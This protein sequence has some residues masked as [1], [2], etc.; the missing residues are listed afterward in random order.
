LVN[1]LTSDGDIAV[2]YKDGSSVGSIGTYSDDI[3]IGSNNVGVRFIDVG[4]DRIIPRTTSNGA[5]NGTIDL[6]DSGSR[7]KDLYLSGTATVGSSTNYV[8][9][10]GTD[11]KITLK[12]TANTSGFDIGLLGGASDDDAF[13]YN[14]NAG[15]NLIFGTADAE[16]ARIDA[17]GNLLVG[18]TSPV[19]TVTISGVQTPNQPALYIK[20]F[21]TNHPTSYIYRDNTDAQYC[22]KLRH[23]G[24][25]SGSGL[26]YMAVFTD[27]NDTT[28]G[29]ITVS[30]STTAYNTSSDARLKE[31]TGS[32]RGLEVINQ[33]N[34][35]SYNWKESGQADEGLL[36]QE[37]LEIVPNAVTG[38]EEEMY[39]MDYS[40]LVT[41]L[42]AGMKEQQVLIEQLQ[43]EVAL[44]KGE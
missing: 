43:A 23:D 44:L 31:V 21:P 10:S 33:L 11:V 12:N 32:A 15:G 13:V 25:V 5:A 35:V 20:T 40:K 26:G 42:I 30:G 6:G 38:S 41:H 34:P 36:A 39:Q 28:V 24:P 29:S 19:G 18:T 14:R 22:L 27:R 8:S 16:Q 17:S 9:T 3:L 1:R 2:F 4:Q 7:F 37:V